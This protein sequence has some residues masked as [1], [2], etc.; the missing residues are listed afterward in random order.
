MIMHKINEQLV[1]EIEKVFEFKLKD[2]QINY[3]L[4]D[5]PYMNLGRQSGKTF[6]YTVKILFSSGEPLHVYDMERM[7][8]IM[9]GSSRAYA[10]WFRNNL[11]CIHH[12]LTA[13]GII[14][15][16]ILLKK[17]NS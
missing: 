8:E 17:P 9:D 5:Y 4:H 7:M 10:L 11:L 16:P 12:F 1:K 15:R 6:I 13:G 3:L 14:T 2:W